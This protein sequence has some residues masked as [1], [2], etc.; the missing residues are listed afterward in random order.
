MGE[1]FSRHPKG[2]DKGRTNWNDQQVAQSAV[3]TASASVHLYAKKV[4]ASIG[5]S[6]W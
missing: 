2:A 4:D 5:E 3:W 1:A 6:G